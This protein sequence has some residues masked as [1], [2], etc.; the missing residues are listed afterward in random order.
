ML[1][2]A[3]DPRMSYEN[4]FDFN[5]AAFTKVPE[6]MRVEIGSK[7]MMMVLGKPKRCKML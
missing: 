6:L 3:I 2:L 5:G 7:S 4:I 1:I